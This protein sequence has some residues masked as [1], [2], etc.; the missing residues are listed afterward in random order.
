MVEI[1]NNA[2]LCCINRV[3]IQDFEVVDEAEGIWRGLVV[4]DKST[5]KNLLGDEIFFSRR[6]NYERSDMDRMLEEY[7]VEDESLIGVKFLLVPREKLL[8]SY[9]KPTSIVVPNVK[10]S[11]DQN[12]NR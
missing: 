12:P 8:F 4:F 11:R 10:L 7:L 9:S 5:P 6:Y 1:A 3:A 2:Q